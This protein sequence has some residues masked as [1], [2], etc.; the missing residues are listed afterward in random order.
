MAVSLAQDWQETLRIEPVRK[1]DPDADWAEDEWGAAE[2]GDA[3]PTRR[4]V[5][6]GRA[7]FERPTAN[8]PQACGSARRR[9]QPIGC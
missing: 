8:L 6:Y 5:K 3:R 1:L 7:C 2:L 9:R 4:L